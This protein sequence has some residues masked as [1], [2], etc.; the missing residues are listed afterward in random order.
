MKKKLTTNNE[1]IDF[2]TGEVTKM[3][4]TNIN[5]EDNEIS[6]QIPEYVNSC[7]GNKTDQLFTNHFGGIS[8]LTNDIEKLKNYKITFLLGSGLF[9]FCDVTMVFVAPGCGKTNM[10]LD[11]LCASEVDGLNSKI[12]IEADT[13]TE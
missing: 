12:M 1:I 13:I 8:V 3:A 10:V 9:P 2:T 11:I 6:S 5:C 4:E 7:L